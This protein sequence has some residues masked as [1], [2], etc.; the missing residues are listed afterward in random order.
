MIQKLWSSFLKWKR[1]SNLCKNINEKGFKPQF[2]SRANDLS[3]VVDSQ[4][5]VLSDYSHLVSMTYTR[6][7]SFIGQIHME[8]LLRGMHRWRLDIQ[9]WKKY[10]V[11]ALWKLIIIKKISNKNNY[12]RNILTNLNST[13][14][15]RLIDTMS[16]SSI[17][18]LI[19]TALW[20]WSTYIPLSW[21]VRKSHSCII[22][23]L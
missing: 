6:I 13:N 19:S 7:C 20:S 17:K 1:E 21:Y 4:S 22:S 12:S 10:I 2:G 11:L 5:S 14:F 18:W 3:V 8:Y 23:I 9:K 15:A 16:I